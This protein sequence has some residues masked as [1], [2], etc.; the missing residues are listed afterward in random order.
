MT[1]RVSLRGTVR[2]LYLSAVQL[3][4][5]RFWWLPLLV[6]A[7]PV[8]QILFLAA[9]W[10]RG[11]FEAASAQSYLL[12]TPLAL[13][14]VFLGVRVIAGEIERR[15]LE[16]AYT[17]PGGAHQVWIGRLLAAW[18]ILLAGEVPLAVATYLLLT[19]FPLS[20]LYGAL[21]AAT[22]YLVLS[23]GLATFFRSEVTGA[24]AALAVM[25]LNGF[26]TVSL[27][28]F[29][30]F[31]NPLTA[32]GGSEQLFAWGLQNRIG[33]LLATAALVGLAFSRAEDREK[34][35]GG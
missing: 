1:S 26:F 34:M 17:V 12:G 28:R 35:L 2:W 5:R 3:A 25:V 29:S 21:Q 30:P 18:G 19:P 8:L 22:F 33:F 4:G 13:L 27:G 11:A 6:L 7:W 10:R 15:T 16:L 31:W 23:M 9:G 32:E 20:S 24:M 14:A